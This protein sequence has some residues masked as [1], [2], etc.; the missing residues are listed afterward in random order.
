MNPFGRSYVLLAEE[1]G[2]LVGLRAFMKWEWTWNGQIFR[3]IRAVD[4]ATHPDYQG[5]GIFK[6]LTLHQVDI[7]KQEG[8][9]FV[10]NTPNSQSKPGYIKMGWVEQGK[11]PLKFKLLRPLSLTYHKLFNGKRSIRN[12]TASLPMQTWD[13]ALADLLNIKPAKTN[14]LSTRISS[15]YIS[16]RYEN[17]PLFRYNYITDHLN[18]LM[19]FRIKNH[20]FAS[21]LRI[22]EFILLNSETDLK[23]LNKQTRKE[24]LQFCK[25]NKID[26]I[27]MSGLQ[28]S[29]YQSC[30]SW[31]GIIP[32][33]A[34]GPSITLKNLNMDEKFPELLEI[35]NWSYSLGDLEVF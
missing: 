3:S 9:A 24:V 2:K 31:M 6:K 16:W 11:L 10:Y 5:K 23:A 14:R 26:F 33:R 12:E 13:T 34:L 22:V 35:E 32:V 19:I 27:A 18:F 20:S 4:T 25:A 17:N 30:F 8:I 29:L 7:C 21:E 1:A 15:Q 28:Y